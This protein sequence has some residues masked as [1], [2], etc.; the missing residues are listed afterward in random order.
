MHEVLET[1]EA[2]L[3]SSKFLN[4]AIVHLPVRNWSE[5]FHTGSGGLRRKK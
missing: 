1:K 3:W 2:T 4:S 5:V